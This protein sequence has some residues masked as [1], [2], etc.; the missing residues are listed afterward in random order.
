M[1]NKLT[2]LLIIALQLACISCASNPAE[3]NNQ[4]DSHLSPDVRYGELFQQVQMSGQFSD[5]KT[6]AD[7]T[8][9][10]STAHIMSHYRQQKDQP[11]FQL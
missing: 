11:D 2:G 4:F 10:Y 5:S 9:K 3:K 1:K 8:P 6:F 7:A